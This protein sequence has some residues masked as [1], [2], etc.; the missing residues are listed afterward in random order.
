MAS[1]LIRDR[2]EDIDTGGEGHMETGAEVEAADG[3]MPSQAKEAWS[4]KELE[5]ARK[6]SL[7]EPSDGAGP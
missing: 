6:D 5:E 3:V 7:R 2:R 4:P 1:V